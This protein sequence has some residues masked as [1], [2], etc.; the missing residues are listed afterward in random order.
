[1]RAEFWNHEI[2]SLIKSGKARH[3]SPDCSG[4]GAAQ[5]V[6]YNITIN[7]HFH[8]EQGAQAFCK[9]KNKSLVKCVLSALG[10]KQEDVK[11]NIKEI[12]H[13]T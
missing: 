1:M 11:V 7:L 5:K 9:E 10:F 3:F 2:E 6:D 13:I 12:K 4:G 8:G